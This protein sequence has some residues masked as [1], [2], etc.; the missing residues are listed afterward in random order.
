MNFLTGPN[1]RKPA[2]LVII[3]AIT[4]I[5]IVIIVLAARPPGYALYVSEDFNVSLQYPNHWK[6]NPDYVQ[7]YEGDGGFFQIGAISG[8]GLSIDEV[9]RYDAYHKLNP[10]GSAPLIAKRT[11][12][13]QEARLILPSEDQP[14]EMNKQAGLI[15]RYPD[16]V[17]I[18]KAV[19]NYFVLWADQAHMEK[20]SSTISFPQ[21]RR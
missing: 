7:R 20:I 18:E 9:V 14:S 19:Y 16:A 8:E 2:H 15:V 17:E 21:R 3:A 13:G 6:Q 4:V 1:S 12:A 5:C 11:V 10:Y